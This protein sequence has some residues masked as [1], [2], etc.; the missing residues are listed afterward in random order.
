MARDFDLV[1][2]P[3]ISEPSRPQA[4]VDEII[5]TFAIVQVGEPDIAE[6]LRLRYTIAVKFGECF[7]DLSFTPSKRTMEG[8]WK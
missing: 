5:K 3:W 8:G 2:V 1:C 6:H 7:I 4:V